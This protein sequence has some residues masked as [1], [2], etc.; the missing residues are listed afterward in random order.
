[1][2]VL[3]TVAPAAASGAA[4]S[5]TLIHQGTSDWRIVSPPPGSPATRWA[6]RELQNRLH[7]MSACRLPL[8]PRTVSKPAIV[9]GFRNE[10]TPADRAL[11]PTPASGYDG[12]AVAIRPPAPKSAARIVVAGDNGRGVIYGVYDVL[13]RL[14]CRWFYPALDPADPEVVPAQ[15]T[16]SAAAGSWAVASPFKHRVCA[17]ST[18]DSNYSP[19]RARK[20][21]AWAMQTRFNA[22]AWPIADQST[23]EALCKQLV[24]GGLTADL[25]DREMFLEVEGAPF[26]RMLATEDL[27]QPSAA[28]FRPRPT[29]GDSSDSSSERFRFPLE[30]SP[31]RWVMPPIAREIQAGIRRCRAEG[32]TT[33]TVVLRPADC[34]WNQGLSAWLAG[35][36]L[37]EDRVDPWDLLRDYGLTYFGRTAGPFLAR[38]LEAWARDPETYRAPEA[39]ANQR[40][41]WL[42][43]AAR[44]VE[45]NPLFAYRVSKVEGLHSLAQDWAE[46]LRLH[47]Q[48]RRTRQTEEPAQTD[49]QVE[50]ARFHAEA[51]AA[52]AQRL[53]ALNQGLFDPAELGAL[54]NAALPAWTSK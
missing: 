7:Q 1:M 47:D 13:E 39:L 14:G 44:G 35:R 21:L 18:R 30:C 38:Y 48:I 49:R 46:T 9:V 20:Q 41:L 10:M 40:R 32:V 4:E 3:L 19:Q 26:P 17:V 27:R 51:M 16:L 36:C 11:L 50:K 31:R 25:I 22:I 42:D 52:R 8:I 43:P 54:T 6:A 37:Y 2:V 33:V 5:I 12:Y 24:E 28:W 34:W 53:S 45:R 29:Q 15:K 23:S